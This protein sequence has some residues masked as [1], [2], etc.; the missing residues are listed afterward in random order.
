MTL[1][2]KPNDI[3]VE[4]TLPDPI[5]HIFP[6]DTDPCDAVEELLKGY[7][8]KNNLTDIYNELGEQIK[9][10]EQSEYLIMAYSELKRI[11][12]NAFKESETFTL[13]FISKQ[14]KK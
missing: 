14:S 2:L 9:N 10:K 5:I 8:L 7:F 4:N 6:N 1:N 13:D 11:I 3:E 12:E